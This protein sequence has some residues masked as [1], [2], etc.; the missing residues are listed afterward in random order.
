[1]QV[2]V[3]L[4]LVSFLSFLLQLRKGRKAL[5]I[6]CFSLLF[7]FC[8]CRNFNVGVDTS[9][10]M[11]LYDSDVL[12]RYRG[13]YLY[14]VLSVLM[15]NL[16]FTKES[17]LFCM[18]FLIY[19]PYLILFLKKSYNAALSI[20]LF[21]VAVNGYY[22]ESF[23]I[24]RQAI[25]TPYL[26]WAYVNLSE[27][28]YLASALFFIIAGGFHA[29]TWIYLP[30]AFW[31]LY[32]DFSF[33]SVFVCVLSSLLFAFFVSNIQ[34]M[35]HFVSN[36]FSGLGVFGL[37]K[38]S[39]YGKYR[40]DLERNMNGLIT[41]LLPHSVFVLL[42]W[43]CLRRGLLIKI[44][45]LGVVALNLLSSLPTAY[46]MTY[47]LIAV[48]MLLIPCVYTKGSKV[49][50]KCLCIYLFLLLCYWFYHLPVLEKAEMCYS[51]ENQILQLF[52]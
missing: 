36:L 14:Y 9:H 40:L 29:S 10:Y 30:M 3:N 13:E 32:K 20:L 22:F 11:Y 37:E 31:A 43:N 23:N 44:Y 46:R 33:K 16:Q 51:T 41:L 18:T 19:V 50:K 49:D 28:K 5:S 15:R 12:Y 7:L 2:Y 25:A 45:F 21:I 35:A 52:S 17:Y 48:E 39:M 27:R 26:L 42:F 4:M 24:I 8:A 38:Y 34:I 47:G 6:I 1:M